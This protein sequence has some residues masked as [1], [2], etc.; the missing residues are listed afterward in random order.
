MKS[1]ISLCWFGPWIVLSIP[2]FA[3]PVSSTSVGLEFRVHGLVDLY[4]Q[5]RA[6][7]DSRKKVDVPDEFADA[8]NIAK[9]IKKTLRHPLAWSVLDGRLTGCESAAQLVQ[10]FE[11]MPDPVS[12]LGGRSVSVRDDAVAL[13]KAI[14]RVESDFLRDKWPNRKKKIQAALDRIK[15]G[16]AGNESK[17]LE[18]MMQALEIKGVTGQIPVY[19]VSSASWP[20]AMTFS[21]PQWGQ[22]CF[23]SINAAE[24][25]Q[26]LE[27]VLHEATHA[28][29]IASDNDD[30]VFTRLRAEL[31]SA[32]VTRRDPVMRDVPHSVMFIQAGETIRRFVDPEH[33]HYGQKKGVYDRMRYARK[34]LPIWIDYLDKKSDL[35]ETIKQITRIATSD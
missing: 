30:D 16:F 6:F 15:L 7:A 25:T 32:G 1:Y 28:L 17:C 3:D 27:I 18:Y 2:V 4:Q 13:G 33:V 8:V 12:L 26:L 14:E 34:I 22:A 20:G 19:L 29:D 9:R 23:V 35:D 11:A 24:G 21:L 5:I 10:R 31:K